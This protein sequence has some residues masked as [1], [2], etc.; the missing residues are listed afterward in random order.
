MSEIKI[1]SVKWAIEKLKEQNNIKSIAID[2]NNLINIV[3]KQG[4]TL[5]V[6][7]ISFRKIDL[8]KVKLLVEKYKID[9]IFNGSNLIHV[10]KT[11]TYIEI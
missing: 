4:E 9:F 1:A 10:G 11:L 6:A 3:R 7:T 5:Q 8:L 2:D